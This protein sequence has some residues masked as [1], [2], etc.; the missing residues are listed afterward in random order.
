MKHI[1][2]RSKSLLKDRPYTTPGLGDRLHSAHMAY[3]YSKIHNVPVTLHLTDDKWNKSKGSVND[4]KIKSWNEILNLFPGTPVHVRAH[5]V[6]NLSE[7]SWIQYL[8]NQG[9]DAQTYYYSDTN[10]PNNTQPLDMFDATKYLGYPQIKVNGDLDLP[11]KFVTAQFD[12]NNVPYWKDDTSDSR[13]IPPIK[14]EMILNR[15]KSLG[16]EIVFVGGDAQ[17][18]LLNGPGNLQNIA[19]TMSKADYH[20]GTDSGFFH[21]ASICMKPSQIKLFTRGYR[22]HHTSRAAL[23][24]VKIEELS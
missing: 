17:N 1:A 6:E 23:K 3:V 10:F 20:I 4:M 19:Y 15:F 11:Q 24:G 8:S 14:V 18:K 22:S 13:K 2:L 16:Y 12:S 7:G 21:L 5:P 9:I